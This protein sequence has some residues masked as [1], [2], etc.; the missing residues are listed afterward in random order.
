[1]AADLRRPRA[2]HRPL[3]CAGVGRHHRG[4]PVDQL[5]P[6]EVVATQAEFLRRW[7]ID[8]LV[9]AGRRTW[10]ERAHLGDLQAIRA[11]S[12]VTEADALIDPDGLGGFLAL[13]WSGR[14]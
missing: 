6:P 2:G 7:G 13:E 1:M 8:D 10:S 3:R 14:T 4:R 12:R 5:P 9:E 11:R